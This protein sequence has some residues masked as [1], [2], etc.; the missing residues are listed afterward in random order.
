MRRKTEIIIAET[1][2]MCYGVKRAVKIAKKAARQGETRTFGQ[3]IHNDDV[4]LDLEKRGV[5]AIDNIAD[6]SSEKTLIIRS[7]GISQSAYE[8]IES[9]GIKYIDATCPHVKKLHKLIYGQTALGKDVIIAGDINHPEI[10]ALLGHKFPNESMIYVVESDLKLQELLNSEVLF[11]QNAL[12]FMAQST[13]DLTKWK[14][15]KKIIKKHYTKCEIFDTICN[16]TIKRQ[17]EAEK[18]SEK[19]DLMIVIGGRQSSNSKKLADIC[20]IKTHTIFIENKKE[21]SK[22][23]IYMLLSGK[24]GV[25]IGITAGA[26]TPVEIIKE[27]HS[28]MSEEL[29]NSAEEETKHAA[30]ID[31]MAEVDRTFKRVYIG[32]RVK[33]YVVAVN[34]TEAV[35]D[36]GTKH[37]GYI[38][39]DELSS[40]PNL[41]PEE[42]VKIGDEIDCIVT[43]IN[44]AEGVVYLSKK[45]VDAALGIEN[46]AKAFDS[47]ETLSGV[48]TS[49]VKGGVIITYKGARVFV[50]ASQTGVPKTGKL[51]DLQRQTVKFKIIEVNVERNRIVG[52]IRA[53]AKEESDAKREAFWNQIEVGQRYT[54]EVKSMESYGVFVDLGGIDGMVHLSELTWNRIKHPKEMVSVG[55]KLDVYVKGFDSNKRRVSLGAKDPNDNPWTKFLNEFNLGDIINAQVVSITPFGAF[56]QIIPGVD[57]LIHISQISLD[58]VTNVAKELS[59]GQTVECKITE[60]DEEK[61]RISLS[62]KALLVKE[63]PADGEEGDM[64]G[65][66]PSEELIYSDDTREQGDSELFESEQEAQIVAEKQKTNVSDIDNEPAET[67]AEGVA[68]EAKAEIAAEPE[69]EDE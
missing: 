17:Q 24:T 61:N 40:D 29:K 28:F 58:R 8:K 48:V 4:K 18:L 62:I 47:G 43:S 55:D 2:G 57:G 14:E 69:K 38:P 32:N 39:A 34:K 5:F 66:K 22:Q 16:A 44:D 33:A 9:A 7:H 50:P 25:K 68:V 60:I 65:D 1:A 49:T 36:V 64:E 37:S 15:C 26:S 19:C 30:E 51:E 23:S 3:L 63:E 67:K 53:A 35:V 12:I 45:K 56:A 41:T 11:R 54:G 20:K 42:V 27:V 46:V 31:F 59:V 21:I 13:F 52:S 10:M 6:C